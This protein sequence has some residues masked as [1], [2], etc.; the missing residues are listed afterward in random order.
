MKRKVVSES[1]SHSLEVD[2]FELEDLYMDDS[3]NEEIEVNIIGFYV[4]KIVFKSQQIFQ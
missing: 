2:T 1:N 3:S 4:M